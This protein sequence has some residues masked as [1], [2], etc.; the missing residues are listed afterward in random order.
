MAKSIGVVPLVLTLSLA[1][2]CAKKPPVVDYNKELPPGQVALR[3][4]KPSEYP[5][6]SKSTWNLNLLPQAAD[7]SIDW[8]QHPSSQKSFPYLDITHDRAMA[9]AIAFKSLATEASAQSDPGKYIDQQVRAHFEVYK[10][11]GAPKPD[12][13]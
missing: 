11:V 7:A 1:F 5:D 8:L 2:G 9:T 13:P 3:K 4:I 12:G 6:F 10:S